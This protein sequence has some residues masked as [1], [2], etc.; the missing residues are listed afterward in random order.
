MMTQ[1]FRQGPFWAPGLTKVVKERHQ[2][3]RTPTLTEK[4]AVVEAAASA[5]QNGKE[6]AR[7]NEVTR[8]ASEQSNCFNPA[9]KVKIASL[10][11]IAAAANPAKKP[12]H[13]V[14]E[15]V[16][17]ESNKTMTTLRALFAKEV[18]SRGGAAQSEAAVIGELIT[19]KDTIRYGHRIKELV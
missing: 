13:P 10:P 1:L 17:A 8:K 18:A 16:N 7:S 11:R 6:N 2:K 4:A 15:E 12:R 19:G 9:L 5:K 3:L 14:T